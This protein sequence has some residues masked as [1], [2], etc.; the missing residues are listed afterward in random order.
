[1]V[2]GGSGFGLWAYQSRLDVAAD[3]ELIWSGRV[4]R[5]LGALRT[6]SYMQAFMIQNFLA[7]KFTK[8]FFQYY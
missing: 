2:R 8:R 4:L 7:M 3:Q 6:M 5:L 1:L